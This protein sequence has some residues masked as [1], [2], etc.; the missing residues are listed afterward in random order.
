M[1]RPNPKPLQTNFYLDNQGRLFEGG[2][3]I[4]HERSLQFLFR[5]LRPKPN[6]QGFE[7]AYKNE[8]VPVV[9]QDTP[10]FVERIFWEDSKNPEVVLKGDSRFQLN[11]KSL[12]FKEPDRLTCEIFWRSEMGEE[13]LLEARFL[14]A[15]YHELLLKAEKDKWGFFVSSSGKKHYLNPSKVGWKKFWKS[16][17]LVGLW[18]IAPFTASQKFEELFNDGK[19]DPQT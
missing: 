16:M 6:G 14:S 9:V 18:L 17:S 7:L 19:T 2:E 15:P 3:E 13:S 12:R 11:L 8:R 5:T 1:T 10:L 4:T